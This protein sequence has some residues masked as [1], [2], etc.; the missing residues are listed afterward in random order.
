MMVRITS[1]IVLVVA[2]FLLPWW[3][4]LIGVLYYTRWYAGLELVIAMVLVDSYLGVLGTSPYLTLGTV[5]ISTF[6]S[7]LRSWLRTHSHV[8]L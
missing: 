2:A 8:S 5:A 6:G 4:T 1:F 3:A 7:F